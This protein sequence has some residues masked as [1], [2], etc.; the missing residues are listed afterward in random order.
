MRTRRAEPIAPRR[1][2]WE[3]LVPLAIVAVALLLR[4]IVT[5]DLRASPFFTAPVIDEKT[6]DEWARAIAAGHVRSEGVFWQPPL[7]AYWLGF[8]Y[9]L[10]NGSYL[11]ARLAGAMLGA[12]AVG[13][14][15]LL[16][17]RCV[18]RAVGIAGSAIAAVYGPLILSDTMLLPTG[19]GLVLT[20]AGL[21]SVHAGVRTGRLRWLCAGGGWLG[22]AAITRAETVLL[23][24]LIALWV[25]R[26]HARDVPRTTG[27]TRAL[28]VLVCAMI[29]LAGTLA[30]N[31]V[32]GGDWVIVSS[33]GGVNFFIG[34]NPTYEQTVGIRPGPDWERLVREPAERGITTPAAQ[35]QY[36]YTRG[37]GFIVGQ[38]R[39]WI[40]LM[41]HKAVL[42]WNAREI[43]R[44]L[45]PY[46]AR[47]YSPTL[48]VLLHPPPVALP[49]GLIGPLA[50]LGL[51]IGLVHSAESSLLL[52]TVIGHGV[53]LV[54]FFVTGRYRLAAIPVLCVFAG[55]SVVWLIERCR[56]AEW[57]RVRTALLVLAA[58]AAFVNGPR[59]GDLTARER[60]EHA[61][62]L[63]YATLRHGDVAGA[64]TTVRAAR[65]ADP[66]YANAA[67][68]EGSIL[69][70]EGD[71]DGAERA[72]RDA[73]R[74]VGDYGDAHHGL[75]TILAAR[76]DFAGA[77]TELRR[78]VA[79][80]RPFADARFTLAGV[81][82]AQGRT[83][84]AMQELERAVGERPLF[85]RAWV[86]LGAMRLRAGDARG[87]ESAFAR[88]VESDPRN[89]DARARRAVVLLSLGRREE[90][91]QD[92]RRASVLDPAN[93][94]ARAVLDGRYGEV[95]ADSTA[96]P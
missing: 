69:S 95:S 90:A 35:S 79:L 54:L 77:E 53:A 49:F 89:A 66:S 5:L 60:A 27:R 12:G 40:A 78:A 51:M 41:G 10:S 83:G 52:V 45:D 30:A 82:D 2:L 33:N 29:P 42:A 61:T 39:Q 75:G 18:R 46:A 56:A 80:R 4:V 58:G 59:T 16:G 7:Y 14:V 55:W 64:L 91:M 70:R 26:T 84:E 65:G 9:A 87:A 71:R 47:A 25:L 28:A 6:Y 34:N 67:V 50:L 81:L 68:L 36:F 62:H 17:A 72:F 32:M 15:Y 76:G 20:L 63:A 43:Q 88:A 22:L 8:V 24:P 37:A 48:A 31:R 93:S 23:V 19:L 1:P 21:L 13:L 86:S 38:T 85:T 44:D 57:G 3:R 92:A 94:L 96:R 11:A 73:I 74:V